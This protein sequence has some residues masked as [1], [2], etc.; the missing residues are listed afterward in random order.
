[1]SSLLERVKKQVEAQVEKEVLA[2]LTPV[3]DLLKEISNEQKRT[4]EILEK[5]L[6]A[7]SS[8]E[9]EVK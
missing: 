6:E 3:L 2:R 5:I 7:V 4:N 9:K 8:N 1:M